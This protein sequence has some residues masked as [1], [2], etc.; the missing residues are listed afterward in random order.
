MAVLDYLFDLIVF[1]VMARLLGWILGRLFA[2]PQGFR[3]SAQTVPCPAS[4]DMRQG[5]T[6]RDPICGMFVSTEVS[7]Q[8]KQHGQTIH[9]CSHE[10]LERYQREVLHVA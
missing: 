9:F 2:R 8:L 4:Q 6:A 5:E 3:G 10:C 7:Q 1:V